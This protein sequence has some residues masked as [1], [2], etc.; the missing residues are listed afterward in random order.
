[1]TVVNAAVRCGRLAEEFRR[2]HKIFAAPA[3]CGVSR[4][5]DRMVEAAGRCTLLG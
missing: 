5:K 3:L 1:M 2:I 4:R